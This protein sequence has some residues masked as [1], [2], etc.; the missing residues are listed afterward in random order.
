MNLIWTFLNSYST[1]ES[2]K[3][4][5][6]EWTEPLLSNLR[7]LMFKVEKCIHLNLP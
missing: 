2:K 7:L 3:I 1:F 5:L 6:A 4:G